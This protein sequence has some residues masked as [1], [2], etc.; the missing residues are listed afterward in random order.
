MSR[1]HAR[2][3]RSLQVRE[4]SHMRS[5]DTAQHIF[6]STENKLTRSGR[7][8]GKEPAQVPLVAIIFRFSH[9]E[10]SLENIVDQD[11]LAAEIWARPRMSVLHREPI[12]SNSFGQSNLFQ[13]VLP[14]RE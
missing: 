13:R 3:W 11:I 2:A 9:Y 4:K 10:G 8:C 14:S 7:H 6:V 5:V 1:L 12:A